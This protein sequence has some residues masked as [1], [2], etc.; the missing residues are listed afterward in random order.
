MTRTEGRRIRVVSWLYIWRSTEKKKSSQS[1]ALLR[2]TSGEMIS[3]CR[4]GT[5]SDSVSFEALGG[6]IMKKKKSTWAKVEETRRGAS[7]SSRLQP[8][9]SITIKRIQLPEN[10]RRG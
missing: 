5:E 3:R 4:E 2:T 10:V 1:R 9:P 7:D 6:A 8:P